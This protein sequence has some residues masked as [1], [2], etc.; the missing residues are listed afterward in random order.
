VMHR[1]K[2]NVSTGKSAAPINDEKAEIKHLY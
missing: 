2:A 1:Q